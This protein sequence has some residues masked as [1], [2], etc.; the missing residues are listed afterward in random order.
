MECFLELLKAALGSQV[1]LSSPPSEEDFI[2]AFDLAQKQAVAGI[3][4]TGIEKLQAN[5][6]PPRDHLLQWIGFAQLIRQRNSVMDDAVVSLC[7]DLTEQ[8][9]HFIVFKGQ[10]LS[11]LYPDKSL[12][13]SGDIDF[14]IH[15]DD[16]DK[17]MMWAQNV[18]S[19]FVDN[20]TEKHIS[21]QR[22]GVEYEMHKMLTAFTVAKHQ[23][24]W[25]QNVVPDVW[26][27]LSTIRINEYDVPTLSPTLNALYVFV[28]IFY[29]LMDEGV[30][31]RQFC[32]WMVVLQKQRDIIDKQK[33]LAY[34][35]RLGLDNAY[36][37][38]GAILTDYLGLEAEAF[39]F[40]ISEKE[41]QRAPKLM[42]NIL[43]MGNFGHNVG[44]AKE[45]GV[46]HGIQHLGRITKQASLFGYYA[47]AEAW[48]RI[49]Y[50]FRWW[51]KKIRNM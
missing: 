26:D 15:S 35:Q 20:E 48:G 39:P 24:Y 11:N 25:D 9:I 33:L 14:L 50:M 1:Q 19:S 18:S 34:L 22:E 10:T 29:H 51:S 45:R 5:Q 32:D 30:G 47:P 13:Q 44:Y 23:R 41:H 17:A 2:H 16:W 31:L 7:K 42:E 12:R 21:F 8:G 46:I 38:L 40:P 4:L 49:P 37:G 36:T 6:T 27:T 28:H 3:I 43:A